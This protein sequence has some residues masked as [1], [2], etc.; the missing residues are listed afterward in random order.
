MKKLIKIAS[1]FLVAFLF[2]IMVGCVEDSSIQNNNSKV[3]ATPS[4][5]DGDCGITASAEIGNNII[6]QPELEIT[7]TNT[8]NKEIAAIKF[9]AV[10]QDVYGDEITGFLTQ[11]KLSTDTAIKAGKTTKISY[12]FLDQHVKTV[13]LYVYSVYFADGTEWGDKDAT[14]SK[15]LSGAPTIEVTVI[16]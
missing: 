14:Q 13:T 8:T 11:K 6:N 1:I 4:V 9:Y 5:F 2:L 15:I 7:I 16:S 10:P 3:S 12:Q